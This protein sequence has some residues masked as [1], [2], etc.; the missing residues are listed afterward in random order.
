M[1]K[2]TLFFCA[3]LVSVPSALNAADAQP[4]KAAER[5]IVVS[6]VVFSG[7]AVIAS[8]ELVTA[9]ELQP[10]NAWTAEKEKLDKEILTSLYHNR[11]YSDAEADVSSLLDGTSAY[12]TVKIK[13]GKVYSFGATTITGLSALKE[14]A[15]KKELEY[16]KGDPYSYEKLLKAQSRLYGT[17]WFEELRTAISSSPV[18]RT[19]DVS[20]TTREKPM[21]WL[22]SGIGYGSEEKERFSLGLTHNN[23]LRKGYQAQVTGTVSRI[24]LEYH[25]EFLDRHFLFSRTELRNGITW[26]RERRKGYDLE[27]LQNLLSLGRKLTQ[28]LSVS[29]QYKLQRALIYQVDPLLSVETPSQTQTRAIALVVNRDSTND[30]FY[31]TRGLR[32]QASLERSGGIWGGDLDYYKGTTSHTAYR[33]LFWG[34]TG[35]VS[36]GGGFIKE[37]GRTREIPIYDRFFLG[38]GNS[39][40]GYAE[41]GVGPKDANGN[42]LGGKVS[43]QGN[44]ELR[45]PIYKSLRGALF[46]DGG[47]VADTLRGA[48][49]ANWKYG[50]G[51]G[52]RYRTP[53]GPVRLDFGYKLNPD[54][55]VAIAKV[56]TWRIHF[57]IGEAF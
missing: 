17:N 48:G 39:V 41:R 2:R 22:K 53:V 35:L 11:G 47:Q 44:A 21:L 16:K 43:L 19:I 20:I 37:T 30:F 24:W 36:A 57:T 4:V 12:V 32:S 1:L 9:I 7:N 52:L 54:K 49:P 5:A 25:A 50:A 15:V 18:S 38:G 26:R 56:D 8:T 6:T 33:E 55:P 10:G 40:R 46:L 28:Y 34:L 31:P 51:G 29:V 27:T 23:F 14:R 13:E 45:F 42:P 3:L